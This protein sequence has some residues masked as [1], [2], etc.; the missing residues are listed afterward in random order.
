M[1]GFVWVLFLVFT[2]PNGQEQPVWLGTLET[3]RDCHAY[4]VNAQSVARLGPL[5]EGKTVKYHCTKA[6]VYE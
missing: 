1:A 4:G 6:P 3:E 2:H 5:G